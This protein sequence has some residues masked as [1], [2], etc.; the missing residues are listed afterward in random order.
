MLR[1]RLGRLFALAVSALTVSA[2]SV[3]GIPDSP[4]NSLD[5]K[6]PFARRIDDLFWPVF[7]VAAAVFVLVE[8]AVLVTAIAF[9]DR[10]GRQEP[11]QVHGNTKLEILWTVIPVAI[12]ASIAVPTVRGI[13]DLTEC[14]ADAYRVDVIGHQWWFEYRYPEAGGLQTASVMVIPAGREVCAQMTSDD[15]IH[16][17][18]VPS[19]NG[20][21]YLIPGQTTVLRLQ[22]DEPG[23][24]Q[25]QCAEF[26]GL[27]HSLMKAQVRALPEAEFQAWLS[28]QAEPAAEP[29]EGTP[30]FDGYQVFLNRCTQ[31]HTLQPFNEVDPAAFNGPNLTH[32]MDRGVIAGAYREYS[33]ENLATWL[34]NPP[35]EKPGS[36]MPDLAL[37]QQ[38]IDVLIA[39]LETLQ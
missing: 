39:F 6:G 27:S 38:E 4:L 24:Y 29:A 12:L 2:C 5:P 26:C 33:R 16:N 37:T 19:L 36:F 1:Y 35:G 28:S 10:P 8:G 30:A 20:K 25:G 9:R 17:F 13:L 14:G 22:A 31:C 7:W 21:R 3:I 32:L 34:A 23:L 15:V 11:R 18:W